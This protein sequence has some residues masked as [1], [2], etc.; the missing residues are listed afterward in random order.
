MFYYI[1]K[2][3]PEPRCDNGYLR[4]S[5]RSVL[6]HHAGRRQLCSECG[7]FGIITLRIKE[8]DLLAEIKLAK[9]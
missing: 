4:G 6:A 9:T 3:C 5:K 1:N 2:P 7:G 8:S